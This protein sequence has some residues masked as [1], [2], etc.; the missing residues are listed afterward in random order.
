MRAMFLGLAVVFLALQPTGLTRGAVAEPRCW[1]DGPVMKCAPGAGREWRDE[2]REE[3]KRH[4]M[5]RE[6]KH[7]DHWEWCYEHP[8]R[9]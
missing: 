1:Y 3:Q 8:G 9:C 2:W 4:W 7:N 5:Q 6:Q